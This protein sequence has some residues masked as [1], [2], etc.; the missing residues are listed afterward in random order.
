MRDKELYSQIL[1]I[2]SPWSVHDVQLSYADSEVTVCIDLKPGTQLICPQC[3]NACSGYDKRVKRWRHLDTCQF[4]TILEAHVPRINCPDHGVKTIEVP[5][6]EPGSG[7]TALFEALVIDWLHEASTQAVSR[8]LRLSWN[9]IDNIMQRAVKRGLERRKLQPLKR[10]GIDETSFQKRHEYVTVVID[11]ERDIVVHVAD[12]RKKQSLT[13]FYD[14]LSEQ[15][16]SELECVSMDMWPAFINTTLERVPDAD[17]KIAFDKFHVAKSLGEAVDKVR[18]QEHKD[19][20][21]DGHS[22]LTGSKPQW[23]TN[24]ENMS[25]KQWE[26]FVPLKNQA[27]K[28]AK[29]WAIKELAMSL[30][31]YSTQGWALKAWKRW[32]GWALR[33]RLDPVRKVAL[34]I[35]EHLWGIINAI[36]LSADN[37]R[38]E[39][40]NAKIQRVK[41]RACGFRNRDRFRTAIYFHC[42]GLELYPSGVNR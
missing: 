4:K 13:Q 15:Q 22:I 7:F 21:Q 36:V 10:I 11:Q 9:A 33:C 31:H 18:R 23:L 20:L 35:R 40:M 6:A 3:G 30:W 29:A 5:W 2:Q 28:T 38:S 12:E 19:L 24:P 26:D 27:L 14:T 34:M 39:S 8:Q 41:R 17:T 1:G 42:G 32:L 16:L 25:A 37:G